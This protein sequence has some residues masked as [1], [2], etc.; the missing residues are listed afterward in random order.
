MA[1][2][3]PPEEAPCPPARASRFTDSVETS[4]TIGESFRNAAQR[5]GDHDALVVSDQRVR[6]TYSEL[7]TEVDRAARA[8]LA[9]DVRRGDRVGMWAPASYE[10]VVTQLAIA[11]IGATL[12]T[13][14]PACDAAELQEQL[15]K[16]HIGVL[17][18]T[19][20]F[21]GANHV[22]MVVDVLA[23]CPELDRAILLDDDWE[24][25]VTSGGAIDDEQLAERERRQDLDEPINIQFRRCSIDDYMFAALSHRDV[26]DKAC[27]P[28]RRPKRD[29]RDRGPV[30]VLYQRLGTLLGT[31]VCADHGACLVM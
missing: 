2:R 8:F 27:S 7:W 10:W 17:M 9:L 26:L 22:Q 25:F 6:V 24:W 5:F 12:V 29:T 19:R 1:V 21:D 31:L 11:R 15:S 4:T 3:K 28:A 23:S 20:A 30:P 13:I 18:M 16:S 14:D